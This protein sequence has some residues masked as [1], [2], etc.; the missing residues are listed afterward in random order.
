LIQRSLG[1]TAERLERSMARVRAQITMAEERLAR[2]PYLAGDTFTA[3]DL[4][5]ASLM[6]PV[7]LVS[8]EEGYGATMPGI[9][10]FDADG[11]ALIAEM[12]ATRAGGFALE[13]FRRHRR[14]AGVGTAR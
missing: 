6:A 1:V 5:F 4:T 7:L 11:R 14:A 9:D 2:S 8:R 12:R 10:E 13:M 3:A